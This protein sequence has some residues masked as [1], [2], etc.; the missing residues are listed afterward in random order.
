MTSSE[1]K[2]VAALED[3]IYRWESEAEFFEAFVDSISLPEGE[4]MPGKEYAGELRQR[5]AKHRALINEVR[6]A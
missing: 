5:I 3:D 1:E 4:K 2:L 6:A